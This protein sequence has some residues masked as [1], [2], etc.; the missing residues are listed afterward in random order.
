M[1]WYSNYEK[2]IYT[3]LTDLDD[4]LKS[5]NS[6][7][8]LDDNSKLNNEDLHNL[9]NKQILSLLHIWKERYLE[10]SVNLD[11]AYFNYNLLKVFVENNFKKTFF[12]IINHLDQQEQLNLEE[13]INECLTENDLS[14]LSNI[15]LYYLYIKDLTKKDLC[16]KLLE[17]RNL[18]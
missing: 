4:I 13:S 2:F 11:I 17:Q 18:I 5:F 7:K 15:Q 1:T 16:K 6:N 3:N 10:S 14:D 9:T 12:D 8:L